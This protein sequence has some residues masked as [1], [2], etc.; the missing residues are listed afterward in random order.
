MMSILIALV[1]VIGGREVCEDR[2]DRL[3]TMKE[4]NVY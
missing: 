2:T 4:D 1:L 3:L